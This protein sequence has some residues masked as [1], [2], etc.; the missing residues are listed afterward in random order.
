MITGPAQSRKGKEI[1]K[2]KFQK[3]MAFLPV[4]SID[5]F[6]GSFVRLFDYLFIYLFIDRLV[7]GFLYPH[8][9]KMFQKRFILLEFLFLFSTISPE[10]QLQQNMT[11]ST[12]SPS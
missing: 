2:V 8:V 10:L 5:K 3:V 6:D 1:K 12:G 7:C 9:I 11:G 4:E